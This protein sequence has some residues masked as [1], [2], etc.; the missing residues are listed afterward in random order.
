MEWE[1]CIVNDKLMV[2]KMDLRNDKFEPICTCESYDQADL[3]WAALD[4]YI[5][6]RKYSGKGVR[7]CQRVTGRSLKPTAKMGLPG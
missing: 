6:A 1:I 4:H 2:G 7:G 3:V 5:Y